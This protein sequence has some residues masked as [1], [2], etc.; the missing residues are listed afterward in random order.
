MGGPIPIAGNLQQDGETARIGRHRAHYRCS[1]RSLRVASIMLSDA[2]PIHGLSKL[3]PG[4]ARLTNATAV[5]GDR[6]RNAISGS[7]L[8]SQPINPSRYDEALDFFRD[9]VKKNPNSRIG[10]NEAARVAVSNSDF[11]TAIKEM[12]LTAQVAPEFLKAQHLN[13]FDGLNA[14]KRSTNWLPRK[15]KCLQPGDAKPA[16]GSEIGYWGD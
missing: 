15:A 13:L 2:H 16:A 5:H 8:W 11:E 4:D 3:A 12:K 7:R 1:L 14:R 9:N 10:H 6:S